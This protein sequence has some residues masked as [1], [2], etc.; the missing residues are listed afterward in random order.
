MV[1][2]LMSSDEKS[3]ITLL[4]LEVRGS[5]WLAERRHV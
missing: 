2:L 1:V 4:R 3:L 5:G